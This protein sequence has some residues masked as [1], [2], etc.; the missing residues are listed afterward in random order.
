MLYFLGGLEAACLMAH[1]VLLAVG[2]PTIIRI[3]LYFDLWYDSASAPFTQG[4]MPDKGKAGKGGTVRLCHLP[5]IELHCIIL[6]QDTRGEGLCPPIGFLLNSE[7]NVHL[8]PI[9][10]EE[11]SISFP[12]LKSSKL[13]VTL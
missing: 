3:L 2:G 5:E 6:C 13:P 8:F 7:S 10:G 9:L 11:S 12:Y 4:K 1:V